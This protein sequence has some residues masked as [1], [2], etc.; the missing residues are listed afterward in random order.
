MVEKGS[1]CR[2]GFKDILPSLWAVSSPSQC[3]VNACIASCKVMDMTSDT[4]TIIRVVKLIASIIPK[5]VYISLYGK[6]RLLIFKKK[7]DT[8]LVYNIL[9]ERKYSNAKMRS[10]R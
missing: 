1:T 3:P 9:V 2:I 6:L 7:T 10:N 8:I 5:L 4:K